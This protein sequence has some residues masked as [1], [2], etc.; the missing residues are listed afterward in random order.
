[1]KKNI[2]LLSVLAGLFLMASCSK[3]IY[4]TQDMRQNLTKNYLSI[5]KI[6]FYNSKKIV[7]RRNLS[8]AETKVARGKINFEN[9][10]YVEKII[11]PKKTPGVAVG[12][13]KDYINVAFEDGPHRFLKFVLNDKNEFQLSAEKWVQGYG[14]I[15]YDT[16]TYYIEPESSNA[17]LKVVRNDNYNLQKNTRRLKGRTVSGH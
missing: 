12:E 17:V 16:L 9:G 7:L 8:Y 13:G 4:F 3:T 11:I 15:K 1:M 5:D 10:Q 6:Q 14:K 2:L